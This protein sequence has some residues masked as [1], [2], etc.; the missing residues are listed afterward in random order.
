MEHFT[1]FFPPYLLR[2]HEGPPDA[3]PRPAWWEDFVHVRGTLLAISFIPGHF[4]RGARAVWESERCM[5]F[6]PPAR[7]WAMVLSNFYRRIDV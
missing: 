4:A 2:K 7:R 6:D 1:T 5:C 3:F